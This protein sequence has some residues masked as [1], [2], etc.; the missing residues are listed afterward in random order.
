MSVGSRTGARAR[1]CATLLGE[2]SRTKARERVPR[3]STLY[4][5]QRRLGLR[6]PERHLHGSIEVDRRRQLDTGL[7]PLTERGIQ[8]T[9]TQVAV[10]QQRAHAE[11]FGQGEGLLEVACGLCNLWGM[12][13]RRDRAEEAQRP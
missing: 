4:L 1:S 8:G 6:Q 2:G 11:C 9:E 5:R 12:A 13:P 3:S 7:L 10:R